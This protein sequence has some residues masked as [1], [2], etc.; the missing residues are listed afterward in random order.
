[1]LL[2]RLIFRLALPHCSVWFGS[3]FVALEMFMDP[4]N[5]VIVTQLI[6]ITNQAFVMKNQ[7]SI[8]YFISWNFFDWFSSER[9]QILQFAIEWVIIILQKFVNESS[10]FV[11]LI[12][13]IFARL[14]DTFYVFLRIAFVKRPTKVLSINLAGFPRKNFLLLEL[15]NKSKANRCC[16]AIKLK[17]ALKVCTKNF[18]F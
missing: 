16:R 13:C 15:W 5:L 10:N 14:K 7:I 9:I 17:Q 4:F 18:V 12:I 6:T 11:H 1:M 8:D 3:S 2:Q